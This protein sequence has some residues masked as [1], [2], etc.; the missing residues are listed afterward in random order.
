VL[1]RYA[2][3]CDDASMS[4]T[5]PIPPARSAGD[6]HPDAPHPESH[7]DDIAPQESDASTT[8][9]HGDP[10]LDASERAEESE[11]DEDPPPSPS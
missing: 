2:L 6:A 8:P 5:D 7:E 9:P 1:D 10:V 11:A 4:N 3:F